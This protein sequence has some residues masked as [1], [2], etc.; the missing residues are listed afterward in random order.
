METISRVT[1]EV[2]DLVYWLAKANIGNSTVTH[3]VI[4]EIND[5]NYR[6]SYQS[7]G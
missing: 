1:M 5:K 4:K 7:K 3:G 6:C 2:N